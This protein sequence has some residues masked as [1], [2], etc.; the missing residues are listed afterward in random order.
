MMSVAALDVLAVAGAAHVTLIVQV[1]VPAASVAVAPEHGAVPDGVAVNWAACRPA[2]LAVTVIGEVPVFFTVTVFATLVVAGVWL[3]KLSAVG[4]ATSEGVSSWP[5]SRKLFC[6][7]QL[8]P[9]R[10]PGQARVGSA[11]GLMPGPWI[12]KKFVPFGL[13]DTGW[14]NPSPRK[15]VGAT[16]PGPG[17]RNGSMDPPPAGA[18]RAKFGGW[19]P[20]VPVSTVSLISN[21]GPTAATAKVLVP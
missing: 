15:P 2:T 19:R 13:P 3:A 1:P 8:E 14:T 4:V 20:R 17:L 5:W 16:T 11:P 6:W 9:A 7:M 21:R 10:I 18:A 12:R